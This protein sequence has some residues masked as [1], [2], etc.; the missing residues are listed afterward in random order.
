M[1]FRTNGDVRAVDKLSWDPRNFFFPPGT[2]REWE[3]NSSGVRSLKELWEGNGNS[4]SH[5]SDKVMGTGRE[6][7]ILI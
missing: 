1:I 3:W 4:H 2:L 7:G 6:P 5:N